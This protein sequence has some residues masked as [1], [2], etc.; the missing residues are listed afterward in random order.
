MASGAA[1][2]DRPARGRVKARAPPKIIVRLFIYSS[3]FVIRNHK[4]SAIYNRAQDVIL[5]ECVGRRP[6]RDAAIAASHCEASQLC[7]YFPTTLDWMY[8]GNR[9]V[10][11]SGDRTVR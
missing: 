1:R 3:P 8:T 2:A 9:S 5:F 4:A 11:V 10:S 6:R 7:L